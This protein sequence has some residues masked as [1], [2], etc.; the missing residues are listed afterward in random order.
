MNYIDRKDE[1]S[2]RRNGLYLKNKINFDEN[3][4]Q[5]IL[6]TNHKLIISFL[7]II[8]NDVKRHA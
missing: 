3:I 4:H 8:T 7:P 5:L 2:K 1:I 6:K